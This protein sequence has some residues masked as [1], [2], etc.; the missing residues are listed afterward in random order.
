MFSTSQFVILKDGPC[1]QLKISLMNTIIRNKP[2]PENIEPSRNLGGF[3]KNDDNE[4]SQ[5][6]STTHD[7]HEPFV[8]KDMRSSVYLMPSD[9]QSAFRF[10]KADAFLTGMAPAIQERAGNT[11]SK[12]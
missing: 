3:Y 12:H 11:A 6:Y 5:W 2:R 7:P 8:K 10:N 9:A 4:L 1:N